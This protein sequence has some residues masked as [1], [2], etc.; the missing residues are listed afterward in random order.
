ML[1]TDSRSDSGS[2]CQAVCLQGE[3]S[4][5]QAQVSS[6][7]APPRSW[8]PWGLL[9]GLSWG[10]EA[11]GASQEWV[12]WLTCSEG[13]PAGLGTP[14]QPRHQPTQGMLGRFWK[15][16]RCLSVWG[17]APESFS[18]TCALG[19]FSCGPCMPPGPGRTSAG[20]RDLG[21]TQKCMY[22]GSWS[23]GVQAI[24]LERLHWQECLKWIRRREGFRRGQAGAWGDRGKCPSKEAQNQRSDPSPRSPVSFSL[25]SL[26]CA[27]RSSTTFV[28]FIPS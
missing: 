23:K 12:S 6:P 16:S 20:P 18:C 4:I 15:R 1:D 28:R 3:F 27:Q 11:P 10:T 5:L 22:R 13:A 19:V 2:V 8:L 7:K 17:Q 9:C 26:F 14:A 25:V 24:V 21:C